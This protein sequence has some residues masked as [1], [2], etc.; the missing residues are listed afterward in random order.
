MQHVA[1]TFAA[2]ARPTVST[3][4][5]ADGGHPARRV[6]RAHREESGMSD[7]IDGGSGAIGDLCDPDDRLRD[8]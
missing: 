5:L 3:R 1:V 7:V 6:V 2:Q 4:A 8:R